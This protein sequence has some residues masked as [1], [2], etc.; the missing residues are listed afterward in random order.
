MT[1]YS[2]TSYKFDFEAVLIK[3]KCEDVEEKN[4][5]DSLPDLKEKFPNF[6]V[7]DIIVNWYNAIEGK[8]PN[9]WGAKNIVFS[10]NTKADK[11]MDNQRFNMFVEFELDDYND[12][13]PEEVSNMLIDPD[14]D[15]NYPIKINGI[16]YLVSGQ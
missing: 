7:A 13:C 2:F 9:V 3:Q 5:N 4:F 12:E 16:V 1:T 10:H 15:G 14:D 11:K 6:T 8:S